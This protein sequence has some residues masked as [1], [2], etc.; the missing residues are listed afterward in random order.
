MA[1]ILG[2]GEYAVDYHIRRIRSFGYDLPGNLAATKSI[3]VDPPREIIPEDE[4]EFA[5]R[6]KKESGRE[7]SDGRIAYRLR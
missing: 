5:F 1:R 6:V 7:L 3:E 4:D 2:I